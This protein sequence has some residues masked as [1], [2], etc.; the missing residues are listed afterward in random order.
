MQIVISQDQKEPTVSSVIKEFLKL[1]SFITHIQV[2][3]LSAN[4]IDHLASKSDRTDIE[5]WKRVPWVVLY[6]STL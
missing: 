3:Q 2:L 1:H 5:N 4:V 6:F